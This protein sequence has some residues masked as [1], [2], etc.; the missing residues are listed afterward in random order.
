V[1]HQKS[2]CVV[3]GAAI[4]LV[5]LTGAAMAQT[6]SGVVVDQTGLPLPGVQ[7]EVRHGEAVESSTVSGS[8]GTF[9]FTK[10]TDAEDIVVATLDGFEPSRVPI[11]RAGRI[12]L[13]IAHAT[14]S[15][16]VVA[17]VL[18][19]SGAAMETLGSRMTASLAQRLPEPRPRILQSLPLLPSVV[20]GSDGLLRIGG[21]RPHESSL[22]IDG[23]DVTDPVTLTSAIDLPNESVKG[24]AVLREPTAATFS[25]A[26]GSLA[27]IETV[28]GGDKFTAGI[29]GF[30][31]RPRLSNYG[32]GRI[33]AFFPRAYASGRWGKLHYFGSTEFNFERVPV[34]GVTNRS[35]SPS[36][37]ATGTSTFMRVDVPLS[38]T[39]M[40][41]FEGIVAPA[42]TT[43]SGLS[44]LITAAAAPDI[45]SRDLFGGIVDHLVIGKDMLLTLRFGVGQHTTEVQSAGSGNAIFSPTGWSQ[46]FFA[47]VKDSGLR[48]SASVTLDRTDMK[49]AGT[50]TASVS[51]DVRQRS[52][53]GSIQTHPIEIQDDAGQVVRF[54]QTA[55]VPSLS[56][57]D[58]ITG[59]G[60]RDLWALTPLLQVDLNLRA[61]F[62]SFG[63][64]AVSPRLAVS[65]ALDDTSRTV[66][67]G[68][69]GRF[70]GRLPLGAIAFG[71]LGSRT[72]M[73][74]NPAANFMTGRQIYTPTVGAL[75]LPQADMVSIEIEQKIT[76]T[77]EFQAAVRRRTG[78]ELPTV[79]VPVGGG[80]A[81]LDSLGS[82][83][84]KE[85]SLSVRQ[86]W[87]AD[88]E[89]FMSYVR[90]SAI[91]HINDYGTLV[92]NLDAP[93]FEPAGVQ[94]PALPYLL[95]ARRDHVQD[96]RHH[97]PQ[98]GSGA[99][100]L[101]RHRPLQPARRDLGARH[102]GIRSVQ[103]Q[104]RADARRV[105]EG[106]LVEIQKSRPPSGRRAAVRLNPDATR[107]ARTATR[108][109]SDTDRRSR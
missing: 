21:T 70:V 20:R 41:T 98:V 4:A 7:I 64:T 11:A 9:A 82:S 63:N 72:D 24:L 68:T 27:S 36:T 35:G 65:Y 81:V 30:I 49:A 74:F 88:R 99:A 103:Q 39:N 69:I 38:P 23:F 95:L 107:H 58:V 105:H 53:T 18:T 97:R 5:W 34:P 46:N 13:E 91:G 19:S 52:M 71:Q 75:K 14:E 57:N 94:Q 33:E 8:D 59:F 76:P 31:P 77:L 79:D 102:T 106:A 50:H 43:L 73:T 85:L 29:Q 22:W 62:P 28:P 96:V 47:E 109:L 78:F 55:Q 61:D 89:L 10:P 37:G 15:T 26:L 67:K 87:R 1:N 6:M 42:H 16:E 92:T 93:L 56:A 3:I 90:S 66:I 60:V 86:T 84:F 80:A 44:T 25:G 48:Q 12:T 40:L 51:F 54:I 2:L 108:L 45:A 104:L 100:V 101:Q 32:L 83:T 17:S